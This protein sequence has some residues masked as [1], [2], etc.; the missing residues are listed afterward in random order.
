MC[1]EAC[2][3]DTYLHEVGLFSMHPTLRST[4]TTMHPASTQESTITKPKFNYEFL[5]EPGVH[6]LRCNQM[7]VVDF[8]FQINEVTFRSAF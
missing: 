5:S 8:N 6:Y 3:I 1:V 4:R 2:Y 7:D